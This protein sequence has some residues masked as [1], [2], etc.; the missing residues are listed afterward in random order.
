MDKADENDVMH[1]M[2]RNYGTRRLRLKNTVD[3]DILRNDRRERRRYQQLALLVNV[4]SYD[5]NRRN[6]ILGGA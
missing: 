5:K 1:F 6:E 2:Q 3:P 4:I